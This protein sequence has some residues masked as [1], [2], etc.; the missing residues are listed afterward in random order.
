MLYVLI[1]IIGSMLFGLS[2]FL[3]KKGLISIKKWKDLLHSTRWIIGVLLNVPAFLFYLLALKFERLIIIQPLFYFSTVFVVILEYFF[4]K[5]KL[6]TYDVMA[7]VLF[8]IGI[9]FIQVK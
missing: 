2:T 6:K 1:A 9:L 3:Q 5:E 4:L 8:F 7:I